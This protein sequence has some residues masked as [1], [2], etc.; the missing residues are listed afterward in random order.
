MAV[1]MCIAQRKWGLSLLIRC[2]SGLTYFNLQE[3]HI[4]FKDSPDGRTYAYIYQNEGGGGEEFPRNP[5]FR[6]KIYSKR[7]DE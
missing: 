1:S 4:I 6:N 7:T 5:L 2:R 3:S